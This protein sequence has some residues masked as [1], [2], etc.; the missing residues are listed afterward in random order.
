M[1]YIYREENQELI[2]KLK[3]YKLNK[4]DEKLIISNFLKTNNITSLK[5]LLE[6]KDDDKEQEKLRK[7][8]I[9]SIILIIFFVIS[10]IFIGIYSYI[11]LN[12]GIVDGLNTKEKIVFAFLALL[13][14]IVL[15]TIFILTFNIDIILKKNILNKLRNNLQ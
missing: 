15:L 13:F 8:Y 4:M 3:T 10:L 12:N 14:H 5:C 1:K 7:K 6:R 9:N 11:F 2:D